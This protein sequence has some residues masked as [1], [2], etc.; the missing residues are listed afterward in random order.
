MTSD[1]FALSGNIDRSTVPALRDEFNAFIS[2]S[3]SEVALDCTDVSSIDREGI[4]V[5]IAMRDQLARDGRCLHFVRLSD[6]LI[7]DILGTSAS[8]VSV[9]QRRRVAR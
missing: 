8:D 3:T 4:R 6:A 9:A 7:H 1:C 5:L 2:R